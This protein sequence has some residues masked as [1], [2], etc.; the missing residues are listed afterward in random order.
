M[1]NP[2][3]KKTILFG[4]GGAGQQI[5]LN[6]KRLLLDTFGAVPPSVKM[7]SLDTDSA[8]STLQSALSDQVY[9]F[10]PEEYFH[11]T[12]EDPKEF[13]ESS[14]SV[15]KWYVLPMP[16]G[17]I[18][19]GAGA[20]RQNGRLAFFKHIAEFLRRLDNTIS[21]LKDMRLQQRMA[22][23]KV[24]L[25]SSTNF[26]L[27]QKP[28]E[29]YVCGSLAGGTG[30]G[31][32]L[33][34]G[35]LLRDSL[36]NALIHGY[37]LL[38][39]PFRNK[40]FAHR[41]RGNVYAALSELD[42]LQS[43]MY[44]NGE[45]S[46][47]EVEYAGRSVKVDKCPYD[48]CHLIDGRNERGETINEVDQLC[49]TVGNA[50]FLGM[51]SM[52]YKINSVTDNLLQHINVSSPKLWNG[53]YARYSSIGVGSIYYP[54]RELHR[55]I[56]AGSAV[57][58][59]EE[60]LADALAEDAEARERR[61]HEI[62]HEFG[63]LREGL[64]LRRELVAHKLCPPPLIAF[65]VERE[66]IADTDVL[67]SRL[68]EEER[69]L[70]S[71]LQASF[72]A[73]GKPFSDNV[74]LVVRQKL[75]DFEADPTRDTA[76]RQAWIDYASNY[77]SGLSDQATV[78]VNNAEQRV[79]DKRGEAATQIGIAAKARYIPLFGGPRKSR[80]EDWQQTG[81]EL[82]GSVSARTRF[83]FEKRLY[84]SLLEQLALGARQK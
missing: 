3:F 79:V 27:S 35:I 12:V 6:V 41:V 42:N 10:G 48:L 7:L 13:I 60:A 2:E 17:A 23:A 26:N 63:R 40:A 53:R 62:E 59:C 57:T 80:V 32:F 56:S 36:P 29:V 18:S 43:L 71:G 24:E 72:E 68:D 78:D 31:T 66:E 77:F 81:N 37:F 74:L 14:E 58:L 65:E 69:A 76:Y 45:F 46:P 55:C 30:S 64:G 20:V 73:H 22:N 39:W 61:Q 44:G 33:D 49:E 16:V 25:G 28:A 4:L 50:L 82:L 70:L 1:A 9:G 11:L 5:L 15:R 47:Y 8:Q 52:A 21:T 75:A 83:E 54:A 84:A 34:I 51:S 38:H 67:Q 19:N